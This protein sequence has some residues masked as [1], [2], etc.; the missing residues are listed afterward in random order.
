VVKADHVTKF[1]AYYAAVG[2]GLSGWVF[3][4]SICGDGLN[5]DWICIVT[6]PTGMGQITTTFL[7]SMC[8]TWL[9]YSNWVNCH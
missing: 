1:T 9:A 6:W 5:F 3:A 2:I 4:V 8:L 7:E